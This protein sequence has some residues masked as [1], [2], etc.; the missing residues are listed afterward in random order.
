MPY[1]VIKVQNA[2][3]QNALASNLTIHIC[4]PNYTFKYKN[5]DINWTLEKYFFPPHFWPKK[6]SRISL[7]SVQVF[8]VIR[9]NLKLY[10]LPHNRLNVFSTMFYTQKVNHKFS[11][12]QLMFGEFKVKICWITA[13]SGLYQR[14][15]WTGNFHIL[16]FLQPYKTIVQSAKYS[17]VRSRGARWRRETCL[18]VTVLHLIGNRSL[19]V[20]GY[21]P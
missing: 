3:Y 20:R 10:K 2:Q 16:W 9:R 12:L 5:N 13:Y 14:N 15:N 21:W 6:V 4:I 8:Q 11:R 17:L 19:S 1:I 18:L 7:N